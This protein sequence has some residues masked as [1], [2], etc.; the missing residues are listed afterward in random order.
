MASSSNNAP[1][2]YFVSNGHL[3]C[4]K[5]YVNETQ[6]MSSRSNALSGSH[7]EAKSIMKARHGT[8]QRSQ[9][10]LMNNIDFK[11]TMIKWATIINC[12]VLCYGIKMCVD[13]NSKVDVVIK[14]I[15]LFNI[16]IPTVA[17]SSSSLSPS[18]IGVVTNV[19]TYTLV[20]CRSYA[21]AYSASWLAPVNYLLKTKY[22]NPKDNKLEWHSHN[23]YE[24][25]HGK[26]YKFEAP[27]DFK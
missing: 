14:H 26:A 18:S 10:T 22:S 20:R 5:K 3:K 12:I 13:E 27:N 7:N 23:L 16:T 9:S 19:S 8:S 2:K 11:L 24:S 17:S 25:V 4:E 1:R 6:T 21:T 15:P